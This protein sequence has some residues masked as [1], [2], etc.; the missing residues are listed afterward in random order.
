[1]TH[2]N[3]KTVESTKLRWIVYYHL[4]HENYIFQLNLRTTPQDNVNSFVNEIAYICILRKFNY[5]IIRGIDFDRINL[6]NYTYFNK[7]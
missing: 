4:A 3:A 7:F 2:N 6:I 1:M 5:L